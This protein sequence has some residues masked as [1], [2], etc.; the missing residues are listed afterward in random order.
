[1]PGMSRPKTSSDRFQEQS[2]ATRPSCWTN[3]RSSRESVRLLVGFK[4]TAE[5]GMR[6]RLG[7][8]R[9]S[10][11]FLS[12]ADVHFLG[13]SCRNSY[14][15]SFGTEGSTASPEMSGRI[16][17]SCKIPSALLISYDCVLRN[18]WTFLS[19]EK[20]SKRTL[21]KPPQRFPKATL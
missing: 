3:S 1:M 8:P 12:L 19:D 21:G 4:T 6:L 13:S 7:R 11:N 17:S 16:R 14:T 5:E 15:M 9:T 10:R 18:S 20:V 2:S